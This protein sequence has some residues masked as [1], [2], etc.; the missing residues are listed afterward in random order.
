MDKAFES[1]IENLYKITGKTLDEWITIVK[2][3]N[4]NKHG[5][6]VKFLKEQHQLT[7]GYANLI[8]HRS[9][10]SDAASAPDKDDLIAQQYKGKEALRPIYEAL[11]VKVLGL[12]NDIEIAPKKANVSF[13]RAKQFVLI[14]PATKT[15]FEVGLFLKNFPATERLIAEKEDAMCTHKVNL[16]KIEDID[17]ELLTW[18]TMSYSNAFK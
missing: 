15:R 13:R 17:E 1:M 7:H 8:G 12:G 16:S 3:E 14:G 11:K 9:K 18:I 6:I 10:S 2:N 5:E 4:F